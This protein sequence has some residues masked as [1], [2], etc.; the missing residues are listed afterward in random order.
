MPPHAFPSPYPPTCSYDP[1][2]IAPD[3]R[4]FHVSW[5]PVCRTP[6]KNTKAN[7]TVDEL[8]RAMAQLT[9]T[10]IHSAE[11]DQAR[12]S[13]LKAI[14]SSQQPSS[15]VIGFTTLCCRAPHPALLRTSK[16][17]ARHQ[18][19]CSPP[20]TRTTGLHTPLVRYRRKPKSSGRRLE[21]PMQTLD[22]RSDDCPTTSVH[23]STSNVS[24]RGLQ[25]RAPK[26]PP[27]HMRERDSPI[28][29]ISPFT[30]VAVSRM[31]SVAS[32]EASVSSSDDDSLPSTPTQFA[33]SLPTPLLA[34]PAWDSLLESLAGTSWP[35]ADDVSSSASKDFV[36]VP[37]ALL[38][39]S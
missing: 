12:P 8:V 10:D 9:L 37:H 21:P 6:V 20:T 35:I 36:D 19:Q 33:V 31:S 23:L 22:V 27:L 30:R 5:S 28:A 3:Q 29:T 17:T 4:M 11:V 2:P 34:P 25:R 38:P 18:R 1:F 16:R 14:G 24:R 13:L 7:P 15:P 26:N 39:L 32:S